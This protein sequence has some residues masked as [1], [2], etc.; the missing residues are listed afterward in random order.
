MYMHCT[1]VDIQNCSGDYLLI[2]V[3][4]T[5]PVHTHCSLMSVIL[6]VT[7][8]VNVLLPFIV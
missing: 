5:I 6:N 7:Y 8:L 4:V 2:S 1:H 3:E